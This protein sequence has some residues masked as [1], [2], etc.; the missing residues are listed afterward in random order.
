MP[1]SP[2]IKKNYFE[3][4][5]YDTSCLPWYHGTTT[6]K[7][8]SHSGLPK[9]MERLL[10]FV[11]VHAHLLVSFFKLILDLW[12]QWSVCPSFPNP[13]PEYHSNQTLIW[14]VCL[15]SSFSLVRGWI[16]SL[17]QDL[18]LIREVTWVLSVIRYGYFWKSPLPKL[19]PQRGV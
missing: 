13:L 19:I 1:F 8:N 4:L 16:G 17:F 3:W 2:V 10:P 14:M 9:T 18:T 11:I 12:I 7:Q 15:I 6:N 5:R